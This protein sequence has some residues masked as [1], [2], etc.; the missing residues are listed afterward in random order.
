MRGCWSR[1]R[2][3]TGG[4]SRPGATRCQACGMCCWSRD[5]GTPPIEGT[6]DFTD[7]MAAASP[8]FD[9]VRTEPEDMAL[10]HFTSGTTGRPK[11]AVH[12]HAAVVAHHITGQFALDLH[13]DDIFWCTADPGWVTGTSYGI[14]APLT[15]GVTMIVDEADFD[16]ERWYRILQEQK[17]TVWYTAPTAIRMLMKV[18]RRDRPQV[19]PVRSS[20]S[21]RASASLSIPKPWSGARRRSAAVPRQL[22]ADRDRRHHDRQLS[23]A[24]ISGRARWAGR[25]RG[26]RRRSSNA[27][28]GG[29]MPSRS[30]DGDRRTGAASPA[31]RRCSGVICT[32]RSATPSASPAA[33]I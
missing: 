2:R 16:A 24:W 25:C 15:N 29:A 4:R 12:V 31:G 17:V 3:S 30:S 22:V 7:A 18:G 9:I 27:L 8:E 20:A 26:S 32:R 14:M 28:R 5:P 19:R 13:P 21:W 11:G 23:R 10:L 1:R 6:L 33:G